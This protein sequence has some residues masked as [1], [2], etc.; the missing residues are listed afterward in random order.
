M[1]KEVI[2][3]AKAKTIP[4]FDINDVPIIFWDSFTDFEDNLAKCIE[5]IVQRRKR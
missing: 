2:V 5:R 1:E 4:P 3:V